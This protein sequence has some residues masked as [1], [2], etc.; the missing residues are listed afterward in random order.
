MH[1]QTPITCSTLPFAQVTYKTLSRV[2]INLMQE[3]KH[4]YVKARYFNYPF[5]ECHNHAAAQSK[6]TPSMTYL[7]VVKL[8]K[9]KG[10]YMASLININLCTLYQQR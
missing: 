4:G 8:I 7:F 2:N 1:E 3:D 10:M 5:A 9:H 6:L